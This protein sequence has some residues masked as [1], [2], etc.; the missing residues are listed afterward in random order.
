MDATDFDVN[1]RH[2]PSKAVRFRQIE[3][4]KDVVACTAGVAHITAP[5]GHL[6]IGAVLTRDGEV[7]TWGMVLGDP[8]SLGN[9]LAYRAVKLAN[10]LGFKV[11]PPDAGPV[12]R[13]RPW[14]LPHVEADAPP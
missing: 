7:W 8:R 5:G 9:R 10:R 6:P 4:R 1:L 14:R 3:L 13:Q 2:G 11:R 12:I